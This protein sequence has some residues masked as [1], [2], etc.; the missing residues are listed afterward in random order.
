M[1]AA[2]A[3]SRTAGLLLS[4]RLL[5]ASRHLQA[6]ASEGSAR[7]ASTSFI[8]P[9]AVVHPDAAIGQGVSIGPFCTVGASARIGDSCRLHTGSHVT[10]H[11]ELGE[12]CVVHTGAIL[13]ADLP[14]RT[15]IGENNVI[16]NYAVVGV[17]C[18]DLK[19][20]PGDECFLRIGNNNEIRE[21]CS[22]H[23]SSKSCDCT[24][25]GDN[26]LI[27]GSCHVAHDCKIGSN[28]IFANNTLFG[29][30]VIVEDCTHTAGAVVV[31]QFC[32][33]GSFSFLGGG[34]VVAQDVPRYTMVAG[35]RA[36]LRGLNL[37]GLRR[38]GFSDQ[39][40]RSLRK[41]YRKV[42]MPASSS[43]SNFEDR[44]AELEREIELLESPS[45]SYMVESI[46]TSFDQG[47]RGICKFRSWNIS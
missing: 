5:I 30:H 20:K 27:M 1:A 31:H 42:F 19:Y 44:L 17:K 6:S 23:R 28:N 2:T 22:I 4:P 18:Q 26:N 38:N 45:V 12:G 21:Y 15:I 33:I 16:G 14:G 8:H 37:E 10:G 43:Q 46:R 29:G 11:T 24:V 40:V 25:I 35:D 36:E 47:R 39:E 9:A 34:S 7:D 32:H 3:A 41:A 13:G